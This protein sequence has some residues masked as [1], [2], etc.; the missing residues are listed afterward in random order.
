MPSAARTGAF[1]LHPCGQSHTTPR[2]AQVLDVFTST[3]FQNK[4][5]GWDPFPKKKEPEKADAKKGKKKDENKL[6]FFENNFKVFLSKIIPTVIW[7]A[8]QLMIVIAFALI[9]MYAF[10][11][12]DFA[13]IDSWDRADGTHES[14]CTA[15]KD[16]SPDPNSTLCALFAPCRSSPFRRGTIP[17]R[18]PS[19]KFESALWYSIVTMTTV[20]WAAPAALARVRGRV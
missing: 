14:A 18:R 2:R 13:T 20:G 6:E 3:K 16:G 4:I 19:R 5:K 1:R 7:S 8:I 9:Y 12:E 17:S 15:E 10:K 11:C